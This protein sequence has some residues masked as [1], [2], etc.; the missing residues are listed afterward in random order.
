MLFKLSQP[1]SQL[2]GGE[3]SIRGRVR[4]PEKQRKH[5]WALASVWK[6]TDRREKKKKQCHVFL[7]QDSEKQ[8]NPEEPHVFLDYARGH[9]F[10]K[11]NIH[12]LI[13]RLIILPIALAWLKVSPPYWNMFCWPDVRSAQLN[14][15]LGE[16]TI[17]CLHHG[18]SY[19]FS[20]RVTSY[21]YGPS[22]VL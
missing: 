21:L 1:G 6:K 12:Y 13:K 7:S 10:W 2:R 19:S 5:S 14:H 11:G 18:R 4:K 3:G 15:L 17:E 22:M 20:L 8:A 9:E 16:H